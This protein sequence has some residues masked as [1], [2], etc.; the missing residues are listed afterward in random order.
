MRTWVL[1]TALLLCLILIIAGVYAARKSAGGA[2][3]VQSL[4]GGAPATEAPTSR[5]ST[6][7][8]DELFR[9]LVAVDYAF[10]K[11]GTTYWTCCGTLLGQ[12]RHAGM[13][14]WDYDI[15]LMVYADEFD[16]K[17]TEIIRVLSSVGY[18]LQENA[19]TPTRI[20]SKTRN[21]GAKI[22]FDIFRYDRAANKVH[23]FTD[24]RIKC[25]FFDSK[26]VGTPRRRPFGPLNVFGPG[27]PESMCSSIYGGKWRTEGVIDNWD[28]RKRGDSAKRVD[29]RAMGDPKKIQNR[30]SEGFM[31][32]EPEALLRHMRQ[33]MTKSDNIIV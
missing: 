26:L 4:V 22:H 23:R 14:L 12:A 25:F 32:G 5:P 20:Y 17:K 10:T 16:S 15:D 11:T 21:P 8:I 18:G 3:V 19:G 7:I 30:P 1:G 2:S 33:E 6:E 13:I 28:M 29:I 27:H 31:E 9:T 24:Q